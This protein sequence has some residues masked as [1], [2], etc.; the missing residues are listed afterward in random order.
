MK[1]G[2][3]VAVIKNKYYANIHV[4]QEVRMSLSDLMPRC[5]E[6]CNSCYVQNY[7]NELGLE[8]SNI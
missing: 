6:L 4:E 3:G 8:I 5:K 1:L 7:M 2:F